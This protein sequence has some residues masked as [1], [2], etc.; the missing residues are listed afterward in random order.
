MNII[1]RLIK[2][3]F[4][5]IFTV[6][7]FSDYSYA[8][9]KSGMLPDNGFT[10]IDSSITFSW[11]KNFGTAPFVL[12][13]SLDPNFNNIQFTVNLNTNTTTIGFQGGPKKYFW[14]VQD[15]NN[16]ETEVNN[17]QIISLNAYGT[18]VLWVK[19]DL[20][21]FSTVSGVLDNWKNIA[22]TNNDLIPLN[23]T[24]PPTIVESKF[25]K[26]PIIQFD[27]V[28]SGLKFNEISNI[29]SM[30]LI[31]KEDIDA[32]NN[33]SPI[34]GHDNSI[35]DFH[36]G[37]NKKFF[38]SDF[39]S[40]FNKQ[41]K[42]YFNSIS[43]SPIL[44]LYP[45]EF[46]II[47][48]I[49]TGNTRANLIANDR[50]VPDRYWKGQMTELIIYSDTVNTT[51]RLLIDE[52]FRSKYS[53]PVN[54]GPD[55]LVQDFLCN[56][57]IKPLFYYNKL[58]WNTGESLDSINISKPGTY[59]VTA[60]GVFGR[61]TSDTKQISYSFFPS[62]PSDS[63][64]CQGSSLYFDTQITQSGYSINWFKNS[65]L[66]QTSSQITITSAGFY[67]VSISSGFSP[68]SIVKN[69]TITSDNFP[70][71][72][73][74][75][76]T[77]FCLGVSIKANSFGNTIKS[78][79]WNGL[80][81]SSSFT[82]TNSGG[83]S[84]R[85]V[86]QNNCTNTTFFNVSITGIAPTVNFTSSLPFDT[87]C[88]NAPITFNNLSSLPNGVSVSGYRW[89][90]G[91]GLS[92]S[93][94]WTPQSAT[95]TSAGS[96]FVTL[97]VLG[98]N[99]CFNSA[100]KRIVALNNPVSS[101]SILPALRCQ[102]DSIL[103]SNN[104]L[105]NN[106]GVPLSSYNWN[107][108]VSTAGSLNISTSPNGKFMYANFG[109]YTA[110]FL[111]G[112]K[113]GC[114]NTSRQLVSIAATP[115]SDFTFTKGCLGTPIS[116]VDDSQN[117]TGTFTQARNWDFGNGSTSTAI[118][119]TISYSSTGQ[120]PV[121]L[122]VTNNLGCVS[123]S[124]KT[125]TVKN[126]PIPIIKYGPVCKN[127][128]VQFYDSSTIIG[129]TIV[130]WQWQIGNSISSTVKNPRVLLGDTGNYQVSLTVGTKSCNISMLRPEIVKVKSLPEITFS[131]LPDFGSPPLTVTLTSSLTGISN[132]K[133]NFGNS[134]STSLNSPPLAIVYSDSGVYPVKLIVFNQ[135]GCSDSLVKSIIVSKPIIDLAVSD[136]GVLLNNGIQTISVM[137]LNKGNIPIKG[138]SFKLKSKEGFEIVENSNI[139]LAPTATQL[140]TFTSQIP[141]NSTKYPFYCVEAYP[142]N[143]SDSKTDNNTSCKLISSD[144]YVGLPYPNPTSGDTYLP[145][146]VGKADDVTISLVDITGKQSALMVYRFPDNGYDAIQLPTA[147][148]SS[149]VYLI[150]I[151]MKDQVIIRKLVKY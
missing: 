140:Y 135:D 5:L 123:I 44:D 68:C 75:S 70:N 98:N 146:S 27:G 105:L 19:S 39:A 125:I 20:G 59:T 95:Y 24:K 61:I 79:L 102:K 80:A 42:L 29:R 65:T 78:Y 104:S 10:T 101:F 40:A 87:A 106:V 57:Y 69:F 47:D 74:R 45:T 133:W 9:N 126:A 3:T 16:N 63:T 36:R 33:V 100:T 88:I 58:D 32:P 15:S 82:A 56:F 110:T 55:T 150:Y 62:L 144:F 97:S 122:R 76:D 128:L 143:L 134:T 23:P 30:F 99:G 117:T 83:Y 34:L 127:N 89:D 52:Y 149:G 41:G 49:N 6:L 119:N 77:N 129:D 4:Q 53:P 8:L 35:F 12:K 124:R 51:N 86:N 108:G 38:S 46:S 2:S 28:N 43:K 141:V 48:L 66:F 145:I 116:F 81:T 50:L 118:N 31:A 115:T 72:I 132:W 22:N 21:L 7:L 114:S 138:I 84:I 17:F 26:F 64:L 93:I 60:T 67:T 113:Y 18:M 136:L 139:E 130:T 131:A 142:I 90:F 14:K 73:T 71:R 111:V 85:M 148:I 109:T 91:N 121:S 96:Y 151:S 112:N 137:L 1:N 107:F 147:V 37:D 103:F 25:I 94:I 13:V 54:L 92:N 120:F 11:D